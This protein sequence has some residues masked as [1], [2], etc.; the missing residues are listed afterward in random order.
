MITTGKIWII[1]NP[2][3]GKGKAATQYPRIER[4]LKERGE[5]YEFFLTKGPGDA[6]ELARNLP[7]GD[8]D[9]TVAAGG[10]GTCNEVVNGL[11]TRPEP[12]SS[13][14]LLGI[15][16][17]GRGNDFAYAPGIPNDMEKA[18][19]ILIRRNT[20]YLDAGFV[21]G[22]FF[23]EGRYFVNGVGIGFDT[24]VGFDAAKMKHVQSGIAYAFGAITN[25]VRY[26]PP[27]VLR[28][29]YDGQEMTLPATIFSVMNGRRM[30]GSFYM[31]PN[32]LLDDGQLDFCTV[33]HPKSRMRLIQ[34]VARYTKGTQGECPEVAM[35]RASQFHITALEGGMA[36][37]ADGETLCYD[38]KEL[39]ISCKPGVLRLIGA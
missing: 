39:E 38:G 35:G 33:R 10:D 13:P 31:G 34:L 8:S 5:T 17:I 16:P 21:K 2:T 4:F 9:I 25:I 36:A 7:L 32:A 14:P 15:L 29:R 24:Q 23:P 18:L 26:A 28:V 20:R 27:P 6:I 12:L 1:L 37:H 19:E 3:A 22:G 30:G 11:L